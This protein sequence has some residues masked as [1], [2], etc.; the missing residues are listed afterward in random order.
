MS[1]HTRKTVNVRLLVDADGNAVATADTDKDL[2][3][4][5]EEEVDDSGPVVPVKTYTL[6]L[7]VPLPTD[8]T[9]AAVLPVGGDATPVLLKVTSDAS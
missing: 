1:N 4:L 2:A 5:F 9:V 6:V 8:I 7:E 3:E